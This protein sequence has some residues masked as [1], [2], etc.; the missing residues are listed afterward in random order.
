MSLINTNGVGKEQILSAFQFR[1]AAKEFD[2]SK[3]VAEEDFAFILETGRLSPS[4]FG[5]EPWKFLILQ[6]REL[7]DKL[8][9]VSWGAQKQ[10]ATAP[11]YIV[12]LSRKRAE[13]NK[14]SEYIR[15]MMKDVQHMPEDAAERKGASFQR[16]LQDDFGLM[17]NE[18]AV[19]EW[20]SRQSYIALGNMMTA[21]AQIGIDSCPIEGFDKEKA[22]A[23]LREAGHLDSEKF[24][25]SVMAA[26]GYRIAEPRPKTRRCI[27]EMVQW[28]N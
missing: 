23:I 13:L 8:A 27:D 24:G 26:F 6:N 17:D 2:A 5:F 28:I 16:F 9:A 3:P 19:F 4:S 11:Y 10:L 12:I 18:R 1:H 21:A 15:H 20:A 22:E 14:D 25:V 7:R